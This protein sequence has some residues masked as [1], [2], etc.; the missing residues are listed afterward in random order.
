MDRGYY[1]MREHCSP[2]CVFGR[3][4]C[5][6]LCSCWTLNSSSRA[7]WRAQLPFW[8]VPSQSPSLLLASG[9][10]LYKLLLFVGGGFVV[11]AS[12]A[13]GQVAA[14]PSYILR[15]Q[16][17]CTHFFVARTKLLVQRNASLD[18][19]GWPSDYPVPRTCWFFQTR[20]T[21]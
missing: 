9:R 21:I 13:I 5:M 16:C 11:V 10:G 17:F 6:R 19:A 14:Q 7:A 4:A 8:G 15:C 18:L 1:G 12:A 20:R 3:R 2:F